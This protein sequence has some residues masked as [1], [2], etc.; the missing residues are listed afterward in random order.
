MKGGASFAIVPKEYKVFDEVKRLVQEVR[1]EL[2]V[3]SPYDSHWLA[4]HFM[5][6]LAGRAEIP[7]PVVRARRAQRQSTPAGGRRLLSATFV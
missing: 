3:L 2:K 5:G 4:A 1:C 7:T 6:R